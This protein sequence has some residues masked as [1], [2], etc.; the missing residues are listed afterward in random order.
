VK[1]IVRGSG[2]EMR[3]GL[4]ICVPAKEVVVIASHLASRLVER[5]HR[6]VVTR[7]LRKDNGL[8]VCVCVNMSTYNRA[9]QLR[10]WRNVN[11]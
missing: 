2:W 6:A 1:T 5:R 8:L 9:L 7:H 4:P 3:V 11:Q 10:A